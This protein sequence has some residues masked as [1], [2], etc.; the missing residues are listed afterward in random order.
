MYVCVCHSISDRD[1]REA[2]GR[3][4]R[5]L[6]VL[7]GNLGLAMNCGTCQDCACEVLDESLARIAI[8]AGQTPTVPCR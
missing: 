3:G 1:I 7:Q 2:V 5:T 8:P 6:E 4:A